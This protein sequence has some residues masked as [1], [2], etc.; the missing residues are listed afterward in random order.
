MSLDRH[1]AKFYCTT[2]NLWAGEKLNWIR[3]K[4]CSQLQSHLHTL[5]AS[6]RL[7][8]MARDSGHWPAS[9]AK[10][11]APVHRFTNTNH[12][13]HPMC[14]AVAHNNRIYEFVWHL[15]ECDQSHKREK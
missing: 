13:Q 14:M 2:T 7:T 10:Q 9:Q 3:N 11:S 4:F 8:E 15:N 12:K 1:Y 5:I 6:K